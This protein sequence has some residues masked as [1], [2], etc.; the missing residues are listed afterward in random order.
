M[1][2][3]GAFALGVHVCPAPPWLLARSFGVPQPVDAALQSLTDGIF[4]TLRF[5]WPRKARVAQTVQNGPA[6]A[7]PRTPAL[8]IIGNKDTN[9]T[10]LRATQAAVREWVLVL[11]GS[12]LF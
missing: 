8:G 1:F 9:D 3:M 12:H 2:T 5:V 7:G 10:H 11:K 4:H 6:S